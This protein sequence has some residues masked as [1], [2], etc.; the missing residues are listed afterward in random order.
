[1]TNTDLQTVG[2]LLQ[3]ALTAGLIWVAWR[4][5]SAWKAQSR[6]GYRLEVLRHLS[7]EAFCVVAQVHDARGRILQHMRPEDVIEWPNEQKEKSASVLRQGA[8]RISHSNDVLLQTLVEARGGWDDHTSVQRLG[9]ALAC[10]VRD[11][12]SVFRTLIMMLETQNPS[13]VV[14]E[15]SQRKAV[16]RVCLGRGEPEPTPET[17]QIYDAFNAFLRQI[18][19]E[20]RILQE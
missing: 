19:E 12:H 17:Q 14:D 15:A 6:A 2:I 5:L 16:V 8:E 9:K 7:R 3:A 13:T 18:E 4:G 1:V 20:F 10:Q 11:I